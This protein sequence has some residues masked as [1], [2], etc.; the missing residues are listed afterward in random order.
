[1]NHLEAIEAGIRGN[2]SHS[3][4]AR[5]IYLTYPTKA[6]VGAEEQQYLIVNEIALFFD[7]PITAIQVAGSAKTGRSFYRRQDFI[8]G[9]SD[10]DVAIVDTRLFVKYSEI[11]FTRSKGYSDQVLFPIRNGASTYQ[12]YVQYLSKGIFRPDLMV[13]GP[14]RASWNNF[15]GQLSS[16]HQNLF[17]TITACIYM[18]ELFFESKQRSSIKRFLEDRAI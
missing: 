10:L 12:E 4:I 13:T 14:E 9:T 18:S 7:V 16:K 5:K 3:E 8:P 15:F 2:V 1:M 17:G 6:F 11:V